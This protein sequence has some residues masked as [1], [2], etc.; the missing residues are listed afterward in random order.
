M[1]DEERLRQRIFLAIDALPVP[2][3]PRQSFVRTTP[4]IRF[5]GVSLSQVALVAAVTA[6]VLVVVVSIVS[7][8]GRPASPQ[9]TAATFSDDFA[10][11]INLTRWTP[12][13]SGSQPPS[14]VAVNGAVEV[15]H[16]ADATSSVNGQPLAGLLLLACVARGD[17]EVSVDYQLLDWPAANGTQVD[18]AEYFPGHA[19]INRQ[20]YGDQE[21]YRIGDLLAGT[22]ATT[23]TSGS[24]RLVRR[25]TR[26]VASHRSSASAP[27]IE[28][29][30]PTESQFDE[31]FAFSLTGTGT[32][33]KTVRVAFTNFH[34]TAAQ[35][36]CR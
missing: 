24:L 5:G 2:P 22:D 32:P 17:Y 33:T 27:W 36:I 11:G 10:S 13:G 19:D 25:G 4:A 6:V 34:L 18:L 20:Q 21:S 30:I 29:A 3:A 23:D 1:D 9:S 12:G 8:S 16:G 7:T 26:V 14:V 31:A 28:M 15:T 35:L